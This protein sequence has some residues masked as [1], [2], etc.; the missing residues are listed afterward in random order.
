MCE[1]IF[2]I[3]KAASPPKLVKRRY[4]KNTKQLITKN[5]LLSRKNH[6][7]IEQIMNSI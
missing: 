6:T 2:Q 7:K 1:V 3:K 5:T 4:N